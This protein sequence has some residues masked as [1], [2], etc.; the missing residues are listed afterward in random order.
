VSSLYRAVSADPKFTRAWVILGSILIAQHQVDAGVDAFHKAMAADPTE[1]AIPKA[2]GLAL[3]ANSRFE[4]AVPM[5]QD[6][7]KEHPDDTEGRVA[8]GVCLTQ[9]KRYSEAAATYE[10]A[11]KNSTDQ[12][13]LQASLAAVYLLA[14]DREKAGT[15]FGK[16]ADIDPKGE[17]FNDAAYQMA[18]ANLNLPVALDYAKKAVRAAEEESQKITLADLKVEDLRKIEELSAYWDT[19]GWVDE[20]MSNLEEAEQYLRAA[21]NLTQ[22]STVANHLCQVYERMHKTASAIQMCRLA[23]YRLSMSKRIA[24]S[25]ADKETDEVQKRLDH[26][27]GHAKSNSNMVETS[28]LVSRERNFKVTRFSPGPESAEFFV[29]LGSD[30]K[31]KTFKVEDSKFIS[32]SDKMKLQGKQLKSIDF[33]FS[34]PSGVVTRFVRRGILGCYQF[35]GCSF[36][37]LDPEGVQSLN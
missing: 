28:E 25:Q 34:A 23:A 31:S 22:D 33:N 7:V 16:L 36:V 32:G 9:L 17:T 20:R 18:D 14:G 30:G 3:M 15:I 24:L 1:A 11:P 12:A 10:A 13:N 19:L 5:W 26:L 21:W 6:Y 4:D 8:L 27:T 2:L 35:S 29:L 37:L